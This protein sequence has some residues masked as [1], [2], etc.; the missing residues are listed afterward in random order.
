MGIEPKSFEFAVSKIENGFVFEDFISAY[1]SQ[2]MGYDFTPAGGIKDRGIDGLEHVFH[3]DGIDRTIYQASIELNSENKLR[4][5]MEKLHENGIEYNQFYFVTNRIVK[6][7]DTLTDELFDKYKKTVRIRD[8][9]WLSSHINDSQGTLNVFQSFVDSQLHEFSKPGKSYV[10]GDLV[11]DPRL[12]VFLRQQ[13]SEQANSKQLD[14][15]LVDSLILYTLEGTDPDKGILKTRDEIVSDIRNRIAVGDRLAE[16][17]LDERLGV[18]SKKPRKINYHSKE[19]A[20][21]LP[22]ETRLEIQ[23]KNLVDA[24]LHESFQEQSA[25]MLQNQL[26]HVGIR[27]KDIVSLLE[28]AFNQLFYQQGLEFSDFVLRGDNRGAFEKDLYDTI[29]KVVDESPI[30]K[31]NKENVKSALMITI[32]KIVYNG[33]E[34]Q[35]E[36]LKRLA[37]TYLMLFLM[38]CDPKVCT[39]FGSMAAKME[40][41]VCTSII[42]PAMS[43]LYLNPPNRR[44]WNLL[45]GA[46]DAGVTLLVNDTIVHELVSHFRRII[47]KYDEVYKENEEIY[48]S[49][50]IQTLYIDEIMIRAYFYSKMRG[51][52]SRFSDFIDN[53]VSRNLRSAE[54][55]LI[56]WLGE[57]FGIKFRGDASLGVSPDEDEVKQLC[58][59]LKR[60][61]S[62]PEKAI[63]DAKL[64]LMLYAIRSYKNE[65]GEHGIFGYRT[66]WLSKDT[67][68]L[69]AVTDLF[70]EKYPVSCYMRPDFLYNYI[71]LAPKPQAIKQAFAQMFPT[72]LGV[73]ISYHLSQDL[74]HCVHQAMKEHS[75]KNQSRRSAILRT[76]AEELRTNPNKR[77]NKYVKHFLDEELSK[78][79]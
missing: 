33:T 76:L 47:T 12:F 3:R 31:R 64:I 53:F 72:L 4:A 27:V 11:N 71:S 59:K 54:G 74:V 41:Y 7:Q 14:Q 38:Q 49:N 35:K 1:L 46:H 55:E 28:A 50:E 16:H 8:I 22:Y 52:V 36:F 23:N 10:V 42:I 37:N 20:F 77:N 26:Q 13:W 24:S 56:E 19:D 9:K 73:N 75:T 79:N 44:H 43:E 61:K 68:T 18:L 78:I 21:C 45:K 57:E 48:L 34:E 63:N 6:N 5:S 66:W 60:H 69:R 51:Q 32:R 15:I 65:K 58:Q 30:V 29:S 62:A 40:V 67:T 2:I 25:K 39:F 17:I 70:A